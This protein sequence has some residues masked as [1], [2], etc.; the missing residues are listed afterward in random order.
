M[1]VWT[2]L[3][4]SHDDTPDYPDSRLVSGALVAVAYLTR[5]KVRRIV[6]TLAGG[7]V[8][9]VVALPAVALG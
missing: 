8:F 9:G 6:W 5:T 4:S 3:G 7:A 1:L 2:Q